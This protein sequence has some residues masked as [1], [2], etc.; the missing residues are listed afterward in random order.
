MS[1]PVEMEFDMREIIAALS[2]YETATNK[3][4]VEVLNRAAVNA[5]IGG[6]GLKGALQLTRNMSLAKL[7]RHEPGQ[8]RKT[9]AAEKKGRLFHAIAASGSKFG[10]AVKGQGNAKLAK[11]IY[12]SRTNARGYSKAHWIALAKDFGARLNSKMEIEGAHGR[13]ATIRTLAAHIEI[14]RMPN[15]RH[16]GDKMIAAYKKGLK[17]A[18]ADMREYALKKMGETARK[19]SAK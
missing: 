1:D 15:N 8:Q 16:W 2:L 9:R 3:N 12:L 7:R 13:P 14:E 17:N 11:T 4:S 19:Y 18:A 5:C 10:K 6:R